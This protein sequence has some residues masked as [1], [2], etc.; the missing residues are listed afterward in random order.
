MVDNETSMVF[1]HVCKRKGADPDKR[2]DA[3]VM[4]PSTHSMVSRSMMNSS[5]P[6]LPSSPSDQFSDIMETTNLPAMNPV[7][8]HCVEK[9]CL[10]NA[11][12]G[13]EHQK[14]NF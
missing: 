11:N 5:L 12:S 10:E 8:M 4:S 9:H 6:A 13:T 3:Q 2:N 7:L 1:A 14:Q